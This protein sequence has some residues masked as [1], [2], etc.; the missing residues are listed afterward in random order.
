MNTTNEVTRTERG[1]SGHFIAASRCLFRRNTLL[2]YNNIHIVV[3]TV[4]NYQPNLNTHTS[5][6]IGPNRYFETM[7]FKAK[8]DG[9]YWDADVKNEIGFESPWELSNDV[10]GNQVNQMHEDV[11]TEITNKL[12]VGEIV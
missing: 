7:V 8:H 10:D 1:W 12:L 5:E 4:G 6:E 9:T 11:V 3:S 2:V